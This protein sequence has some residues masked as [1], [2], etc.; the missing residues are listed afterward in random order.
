M[1]VAPEYLLF[2]RGKQKIAVHTNG[3]KIKQTD[4]RKHLGVHFGD[5]LRWIRHVEHLE[6]KLS[7]ASEAFYKLRKHLLLNA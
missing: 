7:A 6:T 1:I 2:T 4:C 5:K 3:V